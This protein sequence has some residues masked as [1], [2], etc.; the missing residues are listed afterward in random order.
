[1]LVQCCSV[2]DN[3]LLPPHYIKESSTKPISQETY[4]GLNIS[5]AIHVKCL[6]FFCP[7]STE[8]WP[9]IQIE[10]KI[11]SI[12]VKEKKNKGKGHPITGHEAPGGAEV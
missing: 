9:C 7:I 12:K 2:R 5:D 4:E 1:M 6:Q 8:N 10:V 3:S 11:P